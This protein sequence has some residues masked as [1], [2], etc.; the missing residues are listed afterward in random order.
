MNLGLLIIHMEVMQMEMD[1]IRE[2]RRLQ[3]FV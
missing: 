1:I 3:M 2:I